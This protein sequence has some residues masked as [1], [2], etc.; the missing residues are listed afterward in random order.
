MDRELLPKNLT[1]RRVGYWP[2]R[3]WYN[4]QFKFASLDVEEATTPMG[5]KDDYSTIYAVKYEKVMEKK[6]LVG[7]NVFFRTERLRLRKKTGK[8]ITV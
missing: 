7:W 2:Q 3:H 6:K 8:Y 4:G 5:F 1:T